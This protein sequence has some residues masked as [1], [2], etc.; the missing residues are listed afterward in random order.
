MILEVGTLVTSEVQSRSSQRIDNER[1]LN[2]KKKTVLAFFYDL[3]LLFLGTLQ[4]EKKM[5]KIINF[6]MFKKL[7]KSQLKTSL[8]WMIRQCKTNMMITEKTGFSMV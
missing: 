8:V 1:N 5:W 7:K 2:M 6:G 3:S 4:K